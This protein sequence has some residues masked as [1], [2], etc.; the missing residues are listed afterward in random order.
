MGLERPH[1]AFVGDVA[2]RTLGEVSLARL[3]DP[4]GGVGVIRADA[5]VEFAG[6]AADGLLVADISGA[7]AAGGQAAEELRRLDEH[8]RPAFA[9]RLDGR[10]DAAGGAA[11][12]D[13]V[14]GGEGGGQAKQGEQQGA[15]GGWADVSRIPRACNPVPRLSVRAQA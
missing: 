10:G 4:L 6:D 2:V 15:H 5:R 12:D 11:V 14:L 8:G 9:G 13:D 3:M 7:E 1:R